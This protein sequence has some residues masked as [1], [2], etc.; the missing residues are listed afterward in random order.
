[1][2]KILKKVL[3]VAWKAGLGMIGLLILLLFVDYSVIK[4]KDSYGRAEWRDCSLSK[5]VVIRAYNNDVYRVYNK[6]SKH[7]TTPKL[8]WVSGVPSRDSITVFCDRTGKRGFLNINTGEIVI[9]A[10]YKKAWHFSEG[11]AAVLGSNGKIGFID[12]NNNLVIDYEIPY[13]EIDDYIF[14]DGYCYV[15]YWDKELGEYRTA[16]YG[17]KQRGIVIGWN[18][19]SIYSPNADGYRI[20]INDEGYWLYDK[21]FNLVFDHPYE[22]IRY[23]YHVS[24]IFVTQGYVKQRID[25]DGTVLD[26]FVIDDV[27]RI[28]YMSGVTNPIIDNDNENYIQKETMEFEPDIMVYEVNFRFGLMDAHTGRIITPAMYSNIEMVSKELFKADLDN[29]Y[30]ESVLIDRHGKVVL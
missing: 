10:Q 9:P 17:L 24:G 5:S 14:K 29:A 23:G 12:Y 21:D 25:Y 1:M 28:T 11:V 3:N 22:S 19:T 7:Y 8:S 20:A 27:E 2:K 16:L 26:P 15:A 6:Q 18:Y 13:R 30:S 4:V